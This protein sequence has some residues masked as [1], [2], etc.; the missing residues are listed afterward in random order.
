MRLTAT[1]ITL[2][3]LITLAGCDSGSGGI[4]G[5]D[6]K[7]DYSLDCAAGPN[8]KNPDDVSNYSSGNYISTTCVWHC[9]D[10]KGQDDRYV[11]LTFRTSSGK[12]WELSS[13]YVSGGIC[14]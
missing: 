6:K 2:L 3:T 9:A 13:D 11:S 10:Y 1:I 4:G 7:V 8:C 14:D 5:S 12:C